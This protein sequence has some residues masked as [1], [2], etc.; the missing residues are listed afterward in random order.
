MF[1]FLGFSR[2]LFTTPLGLILLGYIL[3]R[4]FRANSI[5]KNVEEQVFHN[6]EQENEPERNPEDFFETEDFV[7]ID[8]EEIDDE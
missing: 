1:L 5:R 3:Y 8:Y 2:L 6:V 4:M 7:D